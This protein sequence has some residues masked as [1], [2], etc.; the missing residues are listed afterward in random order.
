MGS[1]T[2]NHSQCSINAPTNALTAQDPKA[3]LY[4]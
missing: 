3:G 1:L 4:A 2:P